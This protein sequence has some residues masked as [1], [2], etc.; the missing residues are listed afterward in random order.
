MFKLSENYKVDR[1][2]LKYDYIRYSPSEKGEKNT[3]NSQININVSREDSV[4]S[5][6]NSSLDGNFEVIKKA[7]NFG[8]GND[9]E[10]RLVH[11]GPIAF[12]SNFKL[13]ISSRIHLKETSHAHIV[14]SIHKIITTAKDSND[15]SFAFERD[16]A[17][18][19]DEL[20]RNKNIKGNIHIRTM[21]KDV[22]SFAEH[23][24]EATYGWVYNL[25]L[26]KSKDEVVIDK[27]AS[28][29]DARIKVDQLHWYVPHYTLLF[30]NKVFHLNKF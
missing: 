19:R 12:F 18:R 25:T 13:I 2:I 8:Y 5:L 26:T 29:A 10:I 1:R 7:D 22:F 3:A 15:L 16:R 6:L 11:L 24:E 21:L 20:A 28:F 30:N 14:S 27:D 4:S 23:Q 17:R 9:N